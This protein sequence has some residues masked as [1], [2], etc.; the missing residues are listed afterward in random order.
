M[1]MRVQAAVQRAE[2]VSLLDGAPAPVV[3]PRGQGELLSVVF[4][5]MD[6]QHPNFKVDSFVR[7]HSLLLAP[8]QP[9]PIGC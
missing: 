3:V 1:F 8:N 7:T 6:R 2:I 9:E 4:E 5:T